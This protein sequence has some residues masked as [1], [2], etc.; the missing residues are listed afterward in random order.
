MSLEK[1]FGI[2]I[3]SKERT[4]LRLKMSDGS[5]IIGR[6]EGKTPHKKRSEGF[7]WD[8]PMMVEAIVSE[9][10]QDEFYFDGM[11]I[12]QGRKYNS[13]SRLGNPY[14]QHPLI[15]AYKMKVREVEEA[16]LLYGEEVI[17]AITKVERIAV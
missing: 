12:E 8:G 6:Y 15:R 9:R 4:L 16:L 7:Y 17:E 3:S 1:K 2:K 11:V 14:V 13:N 5:I 10:K